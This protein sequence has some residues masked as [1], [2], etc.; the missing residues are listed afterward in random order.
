MLAIVLD[1]YYA[2]FLRGC[3]SAMLVIVCT[4]ARREFVGARRGYLH[5]M[6]TSV[7]YVRS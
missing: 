2:S 4:D 5:T 6:R 1:I 3:L 7:Y